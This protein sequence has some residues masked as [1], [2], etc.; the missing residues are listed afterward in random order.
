M[1]IGQ[2]AEIPT[3]RGT[4][5]LWLRLSQATTVTIGRLGQFSVE[6]GWCV[7]VGSALGS[8]GLRG[9]LGHHILPVTRPHWHID[10]LRQVAPVQTVWR[11]AD[12]SGYECQL[13]AILRLWPGSQQPISHFGSSDCT[14]PTHLFRFT[15]QPTFSAFDAHVIERFPT[16]RG[17]IAMISA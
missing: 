5:C 8:G 4:Y 2:L 1:N 6:A 11:I 7:Y 17:K 3:E 13:A 16:L 14:C 10:Y 12:P 15:D 9:R